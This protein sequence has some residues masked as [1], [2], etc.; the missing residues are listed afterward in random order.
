MNLYVDESGD[1]G[2]TFKRRGKGS[3]RY[4]TIACLLTPKNMSSLPKRVVKGLYSKVGQ[5]TKYELKASNL[6]PPEKVYFAKKAKELLTKHPKIKV[7]TITVKKIRVQSHIRQ[8]PNKLYNYMLGLLLPQRIKRYP[9]ITLMPDER[10]IKVKSGNSLLDYLQIKIW[11]DFKS[12]TK[13][14]YHPLESSK[15]LNIQFAD[16]IANIV[17]NKYERNH[18]EPYNIL[19][20]KIESVPLFFY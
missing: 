3:S 2:F 12:K 4:L 1:L 5:S 13:I 6:K 8:D 16:H 14:Q 15:V 10:S 20:P 9:N 19:Q 17:W 18:D 11:F 7:F